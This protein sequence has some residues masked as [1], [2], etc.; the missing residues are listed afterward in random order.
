[1]GYFAHMWEGKCYEEQGKLGEASGIY[2]E[3]MDQPD[4][5][6][7][8]LRR[9]VA[10]FQIIVDGKRG[11]HALAVRRAVE[12]LQMYPNA[13][14]TDEG[15]GVRF[16]LA[17]NR[18]AQLPELP[19]REKAAATRQAVELLRD[20]VRYYS[21]FKPEAV[22]LLRQHKPSAAMQAEEIARMSF[23]EPSAEAE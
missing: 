3:L 9:K 8:P 6:L 10:Y 15:T 22:E 11:D 14:R 4:P 20:V 2:K 18:L 23:E 13:V 16:E 7:A 19:P 1:A 12:W 21:P 5:S 17:K